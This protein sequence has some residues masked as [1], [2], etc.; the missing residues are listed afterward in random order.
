LTEEK[1]PIPRQLRTSV[2]QAAALIDAN[3]D[4]VVLGNDFSVKVDLSR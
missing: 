4:D 3:V 1:E 2:D